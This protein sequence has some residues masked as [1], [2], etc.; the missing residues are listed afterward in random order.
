MTTYNNIP[1]QNQKS[2]SSTAQTIAVF[3]QYYSAP[4]FLNN[5]DLTIM[6]GFFDKR[7]FSKEAAEATALVILEQAKKD[8]FSA[9]QV[10]DTLGGLGPVDISALVAEILNFNRLKTSALGTSQHYA[11]SEEVVRNIIA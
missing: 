5:E 6:T 7:G 10:M 3:N 2:A 11:P 1:I 8:G 4:T 9:M